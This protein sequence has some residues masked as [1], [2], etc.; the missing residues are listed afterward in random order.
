MIEKY[1][2]DLSESSYRGLWLAAQSSREFVQSSVA[3]VE[4]ELAPKLIS[5]CA[6]IYT[7]EKVKKEIL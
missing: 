2:G 5:W 7:V 1:F 3:A 4:A 6:N